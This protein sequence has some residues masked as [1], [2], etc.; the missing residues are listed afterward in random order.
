MPLENGIEQPTGSRYSLASGIF[1]ALVCLAFVAGD[2][3]LGI[4]ILAKYWK[5]LPRTTPVSLILGICMVVLLG[6]GAALQYRELRKLRRAAGNSVP[7]SPQQVESFARL[8]VNNVASNL[9][10]ALFLACLLL[11]QLINIIQSCYR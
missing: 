6:A 2:I 1:R 5:D 4:F 11:M 8:A 10:F 7:L 3:G 9:F